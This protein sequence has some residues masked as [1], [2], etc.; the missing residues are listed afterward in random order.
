MGALPASA[1]TCSTSS[2]PPGNWAA[3]QAE[4]DDAQYRQSFSADT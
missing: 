1:R 3:A 2:M 4:C